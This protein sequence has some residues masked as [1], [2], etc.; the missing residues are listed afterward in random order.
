MVQNKQAED[1]F[2][3]IGQVA[4]CCE[5]IDIVT[6]NTIEDAIRLT[7]VGKDKNLQEVVR[8]ERWLR[9]ALRPAT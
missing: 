3:R 9:E 1:R 4:Q 8:D 7:L 2:H 6:P 5:Y